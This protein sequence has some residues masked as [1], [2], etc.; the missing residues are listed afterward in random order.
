MMLSS[1][2]FILV[3]TLILV[4]V[5]SSIALTVL[6]QTQLSQKMA[7]SATLSFQLKQQ[8]HIKHLQQ[9][10]QIKT[11]SLDSTLFELAPCPALY[12]AW[13]GMVP[14]CKW[15]RVNT[16]ERFGHHQHSVTSFL[17]RQS[18]PEGGW[19]GNL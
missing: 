16:L 19:D 15:Y 17:V 6:F 18:L 3:T 13:S 2:G 7:D 5:L 14:E 10:Q 1:K 4:L 11:G 9:L 12:A 8:T